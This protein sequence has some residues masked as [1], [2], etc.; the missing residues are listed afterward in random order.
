VSRRIDRAKNGWRGFESLLSH[1]WIIAQHSRSAVLRSKALKIG[2][3]VLDQAVVRSSVVWVSLLDL[4]IQSIA[5]TDQ[6]MTLG[7]KGI[8]IYIDGIL[9]ACPKGSDEYERS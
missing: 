4:R 1:A 5:L 2:V 3:V 7:I 6:S 9:S 8:P